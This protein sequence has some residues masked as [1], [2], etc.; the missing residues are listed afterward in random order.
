MGRTYDNNFRVTALTVNGANAIT[1]Q[2]DA[3]SL[4]IQA[5]DLT[6]ARNPQNGLL[7]GTTLG[8]V[9]DTWG[10]NGFGEPGAMRQPTGEAQFTTSSSPATRSA[11]SAARPR[12]S[13]G[14]RVSTTTAYDLAGRLSA[15][16]KND[17]TSATYTYDSNGNRLSYTGQDGTVNGSYDDQ[18]RLL[19][20]GAATYAYTAD[21]RLLS[22]TAGGQTTSYQYDELGNL[23]SV[24][25]PGGPQIDYL[26]DGSNRRVG[27][28][29]DGVLTQGLLYQNGLEPIAELDGAGNVVSRFVYGSRA[30]VPDY[31]IKGGVTYRIIADHLGSPRLV[32][33]AAT[34]T[35][36]QRMDYDEFG[37]VLLDTNPG[38]QPFGFAGGIY[39]Q[40]T[41]LVRFGARDYDAETGRWTAKD[42]VGFMGG[43]SNLWTYARDDPVNL[44]DPTGLRGTVS[45]I[46]AYMDTLA[47]QRAEQGQWLGLYWTGASIFVEALKTFLSPV[48][49]FD[50]LTD[51]CKPWLGTN[52]RLF[53]ASLEL[54][55]YGVGKWVDD[56]VKYYKNF[57]QQSLK[58]GFYDPVWRNEKAYSQWQ[59]FDRLED[60][61]SYVGGG[62]DRLF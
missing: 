26:I 23:T 55:T 36:A 44:L 4:L 18:D 57:T 10:Y 21:G 53:E 28:K 39:D 40:D 43:S 47:G 41:G 29:V 52:G 5:G 42:P 49:I 35:V 11:A 3:D 22:K 7:T 8:S 19:Q 25:L 16:K 9:A 2:Y 32:I 6:L 1:Y 48:K 45:D 61:I 46:I 27:R 12:R 20:Y 37:R 30:N 38:F 24:S 54:L 13:A 33:D 34:G 17:V 62:I 60:L 59:T 58:S 56:P 51:Q 15:V 31:M 50:I 14:P